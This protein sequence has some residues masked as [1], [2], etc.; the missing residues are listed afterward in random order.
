MASRLTDDDPRLV[1]LYLERCGLFDLIWQNTAT[2]EHRQ[3]LAAVRAEIA[4]LEEARVD[5]RW[6][7]RYGKP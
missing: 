1:D 4:R 5:E 6:K 2:K 7:R 3:R